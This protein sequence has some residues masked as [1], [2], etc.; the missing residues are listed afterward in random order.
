MHEITV[1]RSFSSAHN[2]R[3][4]RGKCEDLH[5]HNWRVEITVGAVTLDELGMV[6]DFKEL[7]K[8]VDEVLERLDHRLLNDIPPFDEINPSSEN[9][10]KYIFEEVAP[11]VD[12][13]RVRL[14]RCN[15]WESDNAYSTY[16][17]DN[18]E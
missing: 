13:Q 9:L 16:F 15:V 14:L 18:A 3:G 12:D 17:P 5:G 4:Y 10:A 7:K 6:L 11:L 2:L 8:A 1:I